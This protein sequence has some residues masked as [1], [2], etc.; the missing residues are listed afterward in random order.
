MRNTLVFC[1]AVAWLK[2]LI[3]QQTDSNNEGSRESQYET[4]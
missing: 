4:A 2:R 3:D 1:R